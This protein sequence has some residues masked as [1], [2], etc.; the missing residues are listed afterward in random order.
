MKSNDVRTVDMVAYNKPDQRVSNNKKQ[1][2][3][4]YIPNANYYIQL[5]LEL[6]DK[7]TTLKFLNA[8][9]G[10]I[11]KSTYDYVLRSYTKELGDKGEQYADIRNIDF[12]TPIKE[13]YMGEFINMFSNYQVINND[14]SIVLSRNEAVADKVMAWVNQEVINELNEKG[15]PTNQPSKTQF[16]LDKIIDKVLEEWS[17]NV[18]INGQKRLE[19]INSLIN[20]KEVYLQMYYYWWA[21]QE[22]Y[23]Y[24]YVKDGDIYVECISPLEAFPVNAG[25]RY[26]EDGE[27]FVR[28]YA[29]SI[30][31]VITR[32][33]DKL[34][35]SEIE[36]LKKLYN[37]GNKYEAT[38]GLE[39]IR[40][41]EDFG[42]RQSELNT[43][44]QALYQV[45]RYSREI[46]VAHYQWKTEVK[47]GVLTY[48]D[49]FGDIQETLVDETYKLNKELG[50]ID[51][52]WEWTLQTWE[53]WRIGGMHEGVYIKPEPI[54]VQREAFNN[55]AS[56]KLSYNGI[57]GLIKE[58][59][60]NPIPYRIQPYMALYRIYTLQQERA[61]A[62]FK[63]YLLLPESV[64][65]DSSEMTTE[66][67]FALGAKDSTFPIDD[68]DMNPTALQAFREI[69]NSTI[70]PYVNALEQIKA[71]I[72]ADA[73]NEANMNN[74]RMGDTKD[75]AGKGTTEMNYANAVAG[76]VWSLEVFNLFREID[77]QANLDYSKA[78]WIEGKQGAY[79][80]PNTN[81]VVVVDL[82]GTSD[83]NHNLAVFIR[84]NTEVNNKLRQMQDLA[85]SAA[86]NGDLDI[87]IDAI[88]SNSLRQIAK[89]IKDGV[90][91]RREY[92]E[93]L[94]KIEQE[95]RANVEQ[96]ISDREAANREFES[97]QKQAD[98]DN[99][100]VI[101]QMKIE[102]NER[103][104]DKRLK[105][106]LDGNG[107]VS[108]EE[109]SSYTD[110]DINMIKMKKEL[111]G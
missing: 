54:I 75:Y 86:Q 93:N 111:N 2:P 39:W 83:W 40:N 45:K 25:H 32:F 21:C 36:Y 71:N 50:D 28:I 110:A 85:F 51:I 53:G 84:N 37:C 19:L 47:Q 61:I 58:D 43:N 65:G 30:E 88:S 82:D 55:T 17:D 5:A 22:C 104:W 97:Y 68:A 76:S 14:P 10:K 77:Y 78:A 44:L 9:N 79:I 102:S 1:T 109:A 103:I 63:S 64:I 38:K 48:V 41:L 80:D 91:A 3:E 81:E 7:Y 87:A 72:K 16:T 29:M 20:A 105:L 4:W 46:D 59:I 33:R 90:E 95:G 8:A 96:I 27:A 42:A 107:Y 66:E 74:A 31:D 60:R 106:D 94:A 34:K 108:K 12:L 73:Y 52:K 6:N 18:V 15:F 99:Q 26:D 56:V 23:S 35:S 57:R 101:E 69:A 49:T 11:D 13:R 100:L 92:E 62:K 67:R 70:I 98:R 24:R 89:R